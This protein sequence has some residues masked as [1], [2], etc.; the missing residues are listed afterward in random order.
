LPVQADCNK[1][2][3]LVFRRDGLAGHILH[4]GLS[5][6]AFDLDQAAVRHKPVWANPTEVDARVVDEP[7]IGDDQAGQVLERL[8][9]RRFLVCSPRHI[10]GHILVRKGVG[11]ALGNN[12]IS[13]I[14]AF[15]GLLATFEK[16]HGACHARSGQLS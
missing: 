13:E 7:D 16:V 5:L 4:V 6:G 11:D 12:F 10:A 15:G 9:C 8:F 1:H 2:L 3:G 14:L